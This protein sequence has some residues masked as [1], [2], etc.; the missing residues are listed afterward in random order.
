MLFYDMKF[1][2]CVRAVVYRDV[3]Q[4]LCISNFGVGVSQSE[5]LMESY[6]VARVVGPF[7]KFSSFAGRCP[8]LAGYGRSLYAAP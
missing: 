8:A 5:V 2:D 1:L 7:G 4:Y 6:A 3:V